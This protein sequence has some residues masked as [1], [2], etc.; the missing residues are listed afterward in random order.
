[1]ISL[2]STFINRRKLFESQLFALC[3]RIVIVSLVA[4]VGAIATLV[5]DGVTDSAQESDVLVVLGNEVLSSGEPSDRLAAR[6]DKAIELYDKSLAPTIIVSGGFGVSGFDEAEVMANYLLANNVP[7]DSIIRDNEGITTGAT[8]T[9]VAAI[10]EQRNWDSAIVVSQYYH[11]SRSRLAHRRA[12]ID[13]VTTAHASYIEAR[14]A[15]SLLREVP[16]YTKYFFTS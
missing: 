1:M 9:N 8:A 16:A 10:M 4:Y 15:Y 14:D 3:R 5:F 7:A 11:I 12:G 6:L 2:R 13:S